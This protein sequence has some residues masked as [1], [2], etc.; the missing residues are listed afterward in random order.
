M[1][2]LKNLFPAQS[3]EQIREESERQ[4]QEFLARGGTVQVVGKKKG[5]TKLTANGKTSGQVFVNVHN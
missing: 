2:I 1:G 3:K 4:M 5:P